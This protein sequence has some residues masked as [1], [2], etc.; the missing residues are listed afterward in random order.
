MLL[1]LTIGLTVFA[2][3]VFQWYRAGAARENLRLPALAMLAFITGF[4]WAAWRAEWRLADELASALEA[5]DIEISG[6]VA[7]LPDISEQGTR[8]VFRVEQSDAGVPSRILLHWGG[9]SSVRPGERWHF[10][11]RLKRPH[12]LANPHGYDYEAALLERGIRATGNVRAKPAPRRLDEFVVSPA[13]VVD[14]MRDA[15]RVRFAATLKGENY[16]GVLTALAVGDQRAIPDE[17][18]KVFRAVGISHLIS[19]SGLHVS[20]VGL[21]VGWLAGKGWRRS[22]KRL[23]QVPAVKVASLTGLAGAAAYAVLAG[24]GIPTQR[25][26]IMI[27]VVAAALLG[28]RQPSGGQVISLALLCVLLFDP[29]AVLAPGFWLSFGAVA[30]LMFLLGGRAAAAKGWRAAAWAQLGITLAMIPALLVLFNAFS[31]VSPAANA[32]AIPVVSFIVTP[33]T[34]LAIVVPLDT[35]LEIAHG[36]FSALM[37]L[38]DALARLP[39]AMWVQPAPPGVLAAA[40]IAGVAWLLLPRGTPARAAG[41]FALVPMMSWAPD[42]PAEGE[43]RAAVLDVGQGTA[44]HLRTARHDLL[45][46]TGPA[47]RGGGDVGERVLLP[48]LSAVG[49]SR[50]D[51]VI[52]SHDDLDH[53]GGLQSLL[54]GARVREL[55]MNRKEGA[56]SLTMPQTLLRPCEA[57]AEWSWDGVEFR[58]L[59]PAAEQAGELSDND[60][61]CVLR[62]STLG[63][64]LLLAGDIERSAERRLVGELGA[65]LAST[66]VVV[67]HHGSRSSSSQE[68]VAATGAEVAVHSS[69]YL[70]QFHHPHPSVLERW[71]AVGAQ[72]WRTD[73]QGAI[74]LHV[75]ARGVQT[76]AQR[77]IVRR[78]WSGR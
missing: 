69:G 19:I 39:F 76:A 30:I 45:Y 5:Q 28:G 49:V 26:L 56:A 67:P 47:Y 18:W 38:L 16:A 9:G 35:P 65:D 36:V 10:A 51:R 62:V 25:S 43:F 75:D 42:R 41:L 70:N 14:R 68:F 33:L 1:A 12:G 20:M 29:W 11:V 71:A 77:E 59:H 13:A 40:G 50:L 58:V 3:A 2:A 6:V 54:G 55:W 32:V 8:F 46:D 7:E 72:N 44:V 31:I 57:G 4:A 17:Q 53:S 15:I 34:L 22:G 73:H 63:G 23:L 61:S 52:V 24:M 21:L 64:S 66:V 78:Y 48:Y 74:H 37:V 60:A 27:A